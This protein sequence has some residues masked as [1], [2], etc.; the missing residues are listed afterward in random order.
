MPAHA[1]ETPSA[2]WTRVA[3]ATAE[4]NK[5]LVR[6]L[7]QEAFNEG[8]LE[9]IPELVHPDYVYRSPGEVIDGADGL[10]ALIGAYRGAFPD[11]HIRIDELIAAED[12]TTLSFT[13]TGTH[14]GD[15]LGNPPT[16]RSVRVH[17][18]V[19]SRFEGGRIRDEWELLDMLGL[20]EQLGIVGAKA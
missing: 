15:L 4:E 18:I 9:V 13:L 14:R 12:A 17:G 1:P 16:G 11:L 6:R 19:R 7:I 8:K 2:R 10:A 5:R 20:F 3:D